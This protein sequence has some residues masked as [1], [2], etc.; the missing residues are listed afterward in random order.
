MFCAPGKPSEQAGG[1][2]EG[3]WDVLLSAGGMGAETRRE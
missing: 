1:G 2:G 3:S